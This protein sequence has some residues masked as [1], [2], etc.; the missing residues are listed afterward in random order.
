M[1]DFP[2]NND[3]PTP[4]L[5]LD[6]VSKSFFSKGTPL[7]VLRDI[8]LEMH[9]AEFVCMLGES[10]CGKTTLLNII[11]GSETCTS[12]QVFM[13]GNPVNE[14]H[15]SRGMV[16]QK[17]LLY[18]W[19]NV[20]KNVRLG[21]DIRGDTKNMHQRVS[22]AIHLVGLEGFEDYKPSQISGGMAQRVSLARALVNEPEILLLDEPFGALDAVTRRRMQEELL[23]IWE[24]Q[25]CTMVFVTHDIDEAILLGTRIVV[26]SPRPGE[27]REILDVPLSHP[28]SRNS[29]EFLAFRA[30][31]STIF[32]AATEHFAYA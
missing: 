14:P 9:N 17:P 20:K 30:E 32:F 3:H 16:F 10:G 6:S 31:V 26:M 24:K 13:D 25:T 5:Y 18:P 4:K 27:I 21:L 11:A 22:R 19:L 7:E 29:R 1:T 23:H 12:G 2:T 15:A 8:T 28:R